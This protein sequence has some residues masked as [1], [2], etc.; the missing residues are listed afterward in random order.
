MVSENIST[1][2]MVPKGQ[3]LRISNST[4]RNLQNGKARFRFLYIG[5]HLATEEVLLRQFETGD[6]AYNFGDAKK[7][8]LAESSRAAGCLYDVIFIDYPLDR[9]ELKKF[10]S[11]LRRN[12]FSK[13]VLVYNGTRLTDNCIKNIRRF[14]RI[15]DVF[16]I[17]SNDINYAAI[18]PFLRSSKRAHRLRRLRV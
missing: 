8:M 9:S 4:A 5:S 16:D 18:I 7:M 17:Q 3:W 15:D 11:F 10:F 2:P 6:M 1:E 12:K 14:D 13:L